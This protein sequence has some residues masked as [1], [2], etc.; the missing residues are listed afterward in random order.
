M[1][2]FQAPG[3]ASRVEPTVALSC[4]CEHT[5][6]VIDDGLPGSRK[7]RD[8]GHPPQQLG[9]KFASFS[10]MLVRPITIGIIP[11]TNPRQ[12]ACGNIYAGEQ[13]ANIRISSQTPQCGIGVGNFRSKK[14]PVVALMERHK[15]GGRVRSF[16]I[17]RVSVGNVKPI[18]KAHVEAGTNIQTDEAT[19]YHFMHNDFPD[20]DFVTHSRKE[21]SGVRMIATSQRTR[22]R[23][24]SAYQRALPHK[25]QR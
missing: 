15:A 7:T 2:A 16:P 21:Y 14:R 22:L 19:I 17:E 25:K 18:M 12:P 1:P 6:Q 20:H 10:W 8:P 11:F 3:H 13:K 5:R 4:D 9:A 23:G 24:T